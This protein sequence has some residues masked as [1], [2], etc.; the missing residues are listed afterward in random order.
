MAIAG[1]G[2]QY[3]MMSGNAIYMQDKENGEIASVS[4]NFRLN[5]TVVALR[6]PLERK[7]FYYL[8]YVE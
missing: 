4:D 6:V 3:I 7:E 2:G 8:N 5:G 1:M